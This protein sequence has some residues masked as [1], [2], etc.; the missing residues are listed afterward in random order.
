MRI[1]V[2]HH[3]HYAGEDALLRELRALR[4]HF[5]TRMDQM[6]T[7]FGDVLGRIDAATNNIAEDIRNIKDQLS[8]GMN[9]A[10]VAALK[11]QLEA[12]ASTLEGIASS[13]EDPVPEQPTEPTEPPTEPPVDGTP[14]S[15]R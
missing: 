10:Q 2:H 1:D 4:N 9:A 3:L 8:T 13:T 7:D 14:F 6:A 11:Q 5:D 12:K 15:G